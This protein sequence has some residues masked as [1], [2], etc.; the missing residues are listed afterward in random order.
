[1]LGE[2]DATYNGCEDDCR[3][4]YGVTNFSWHL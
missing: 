2:G 3:L 1:V 4:G